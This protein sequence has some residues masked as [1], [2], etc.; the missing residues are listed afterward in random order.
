MDLVSLAATIIG[1]TATVAT[2]VWNTHT[3]KRNTEKL[4][5]STAAKRVEMFLTND[6][7]RNAYN[8]IDVGDF[9]FPPEG[10]RTPEYFRADEMEPRLRTSS[11]PC[12]ND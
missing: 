5:R 12:H 6:L 8:P 4:R 2:L 11:P 3:F 9:E 1:L 10:E 7:L